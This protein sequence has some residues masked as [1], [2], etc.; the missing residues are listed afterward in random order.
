MVAETASLEYRPCVGIVLFNKQGKVFA[1]KRL[2]SK[3]GEAAL[4]SGAWQFP[5][6]GIEAGEKPLAAAYRELHE[7]TSITSVQ[8]LQELPDWY[9]Y[10]FPDFVLRSQRSNVYKGQKQKWFAFLFT[11][12]PEEIDIVNLPNNA[13]PEF[14]A[15]EWKDLA[16]M[17]SLVVDF[18]R[19]VYK[20]IVL[21]F[22]NLPLNLS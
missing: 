3:K 12:L 21:K 5:Q 2:F 16:D 14:S 11:G 8:L 19:E 7:E 10:T 13:K 9:S 1:G 6:G 17:P 18:K 4:S 15:W 22:S 20:E